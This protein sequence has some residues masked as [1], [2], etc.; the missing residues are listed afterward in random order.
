MS[1]IK[2]SGCRFCR[3]SGLLNDIKAW[4]RQRGN[5]WNQEVRVPLL[6]GQRTTSRGGAN[7][8]RYPQ[9]STMCLC[10]PMATCSKMCMRS[11]VDQKHNLLN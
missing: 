11:S 1:G 4:C 9:T 3:G 5:E 8:A 6:S 2:R 7:E 10:A